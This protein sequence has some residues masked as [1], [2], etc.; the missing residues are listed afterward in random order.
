MS[1][2]KELEKRMESSAQATG[3]LRLFGESIT[4]A[5]RTLVDPQT[6][7]QLPRLF[8]EGFGPVRRMVIQAHNTGEISRRLQNRERVTFVTSFPRSGNTWMRFL[9]SDIFLQNHGIETAT[10]LKV[11]PD[12]IIADFYCDWIA[13]RNPH[14]QTP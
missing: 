3:I 7:S 6:L 2:V 5:L 12:G 10:D 1:Q 4:P 9:L 14:V 8:R 13:R 11:Q